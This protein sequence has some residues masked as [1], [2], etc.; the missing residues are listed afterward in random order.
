MIKLP[1]SHCILRCAARAAAGRVRSHS[2]VIRRTVS[3]R[4]TP[5]CHRTVHPEPPSESESGEATEGPG[6]I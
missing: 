5:H 1:G 4:P 2:R 6:M 3:A